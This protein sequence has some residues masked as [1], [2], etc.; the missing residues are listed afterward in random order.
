M[1]EK[2]KKEYAI[3]LLKLEK[4]MQSETTPQHYKEEIM[5]KM[6]EVTE[7]MIQNHGIESLF[8]IEDYIEKFLKV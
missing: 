3:K 8:E 4:I 5:Q 1:K 2:V 7:N 6:S